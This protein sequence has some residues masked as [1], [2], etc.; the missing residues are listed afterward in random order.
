MLCNGGHAAMKAH[1]VAAWQHQRMHEGMA[2]CGRQCMRGRRQPAA[3]A[4]NAFSATPGIAV[5]Q[6]QRTREGMAWRS[7]GFATDGWSEFTGRRDG[8]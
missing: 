4:A 2:W 1:Q 6:R 5:A 8:P 3:T 7:G